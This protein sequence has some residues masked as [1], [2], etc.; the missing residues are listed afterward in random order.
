[1]GNLQAGFVPHFAA[2]KE[3]GGHFFR[4]VAY[5]MGLILIVM[6]TLLEGLLWAL[7]SLVSSDWLSIIDLTMWMVP[8]LFFICLYGLNS[9]LLQCRKKY[10]IPA[11]APVVF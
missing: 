3:E 8:G 2:L 4:D 9:S 11:A 5:S 6:I 1:E 10:F 7:R